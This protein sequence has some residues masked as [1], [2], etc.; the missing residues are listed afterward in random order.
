[1]NTYKNDW[2]FAQLSGARKKEKATLGLLPYALIEIVLV[3]VEIK[4]LMG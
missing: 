1:M 3:L 2:T 4:Y